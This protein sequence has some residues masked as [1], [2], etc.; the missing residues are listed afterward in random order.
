LLPPGEG[1]ADG[2]RASGHLDLREFG[3]RGGEGKRPEGREKPRREVDVR[4]QK[5]AG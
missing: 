1:K 3:T 2:G 4:L 5:Q